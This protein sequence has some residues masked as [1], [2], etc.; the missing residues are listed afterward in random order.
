MCACIANYNAFSML[1]Q[2]FVVASNPVV[3][4]S[5]FAKIKKSFQKALFLR[6]DSHRKTIDLTLFNKLANKIARNTAKFFGAAKTRSR[7]R[8]H[9]TVP[10]LSLKFCKNAFSKTK[11][12]KTRNLETRWIPGPKQRRS[13]RGPKTTV[14]RV[15]LKILITFWLLNCRRHPSSPPS[16]TDPLALT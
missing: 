15:S 2:N 11:H 16:L 10:R 4:I 8:V 7:S 5:P 13:R 6:H 12:Q 3:G 1:Q 9:H 14:P